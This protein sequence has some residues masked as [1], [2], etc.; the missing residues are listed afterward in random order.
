MGIMARINTRR[1]RMMYRLHRFTARLP[2]WL[3]PFRARR[4]SGYPQVYQGAGEPDF[5]PGQGIWVRTLDA[6]LAQLAW[7]DMLKKSELEPG[8]I[9]QVQTTYSIYEL[10]I[11]DQDE[12]LVS[13]GWFDKHNLS[14]YRARINGCTWGGSAI[15]HDIIAGA[16][17]HI[18]FSIGGRNILTTSPIRGWIVYGKSNPREALPL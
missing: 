10:L 4:W 5:Q 8:S 11:L 1:A 17:M 14:P 18:E 7:L 9:V 3:W 12:V 15:K 16:M 2:R 6:E 13:G